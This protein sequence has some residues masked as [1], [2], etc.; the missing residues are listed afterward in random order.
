MLISLVV[1]FIVV[2]VC[3]LL[4]FEAINILTNTLFK[5]KATPRIRILL[6][7]FACFLRTYWKC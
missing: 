6:S 2:A 4:H 7:L 1:N 3:V 5:P